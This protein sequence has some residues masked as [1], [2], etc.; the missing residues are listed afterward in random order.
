MPAQLPRRT[1]A[2]LAQLADRGRS[3]ADIA[4]RLGVSETTVRRY[5]RARDEA[6]APA[7]AAASA[8]VQSFG[9]PEPPPTGPFQPGPRPSPNIPPPAWTTAEPPPPPATVVYRP[10]Y[11]DLT[12]RAPPAPLSFEGWTVERIRSAIAQHDLGIFLESSQLMITLTRFGPVHTALSQ[13]IAPVLGLPRLVTGG[14]RGLSRILAAEIEAQ[15]A[16][17][18]GLLP[19]PHFPPTIWGSV[20]VERVMMGFAALQHV[21]GE[22]DPQYDVRP[23]YTRRWPTWAIYYYPARRTFVA[24]TDAGPVDIITGDGKFSLLADRDDPHH[25]GAVRALGLEVLAGVLADQALAS[26]INRYGNPK[27]WIEMP[28]NVPTQGPEGDTMFASIQT[29]QGPNG[30]MVVPHGAGVNVAQ[31]AASQSALFKE[32]NEKITARCAGILLGSDGTITSGTGGV[33]QSPYFWGVRRDI[34]MRLI[35]SL[36]RGVN[37]GHVKPYLDMNYAAAIAETRAWVEPVLSMPLPDPDADARHESAAER[38]I[39]RTEAITKER[40]AGI[41]VTQERVDQISE[42]LGLER[43]ALAAS[44]RTAVPLDIAPT[45]LAKTVRVREVRAS[46]GLPPLGDERDDL[47]LAQLD[48]AALTAA[49]RGTPTPA[50]PP[51]EDEPDDS[52]AEEPAD[53][54]DGGGSGDTAEAEDVP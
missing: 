21:Y 40:A 53:P 34:V 3:T 31:I 19:S 18:A 29:I 49:T 11:H 26:F 50:A 1:A 14:T 37:A 43:V 22:P 25:E 38:M 42:S 7:A 12:L 16:P 46:R 2:K 10:G 24:N 51:P 52:P 47:L 8:A 9:A 5:R 17:R 32:A 6:P 39:Q 4:R 44:E 41:D 23:I 28:E 13:A 45:D 15:L 30:V 27:W 54:E 35:N 20:A 36:V 33:Y 48:P